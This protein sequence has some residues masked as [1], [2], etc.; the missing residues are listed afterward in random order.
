M[1]TCYR[2]SQVWTLVLIRFKD[3]DAE[4]VYLSA[5]II[6]FCYG[7]RSSVFII[8]FF[9]FSTKSTFPINILCAETTKLYKQDNYRDKLNARTLWGFSN[10]CS[11]GLSIPTRATNGVSLG[12]GFSRWLVNGREGESSWKFEYCHHSCDSAW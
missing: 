6:D 4:E 1:M 3:G 12:A 11:A 7:A 10:N 5:D 9:V 8:F 2:S